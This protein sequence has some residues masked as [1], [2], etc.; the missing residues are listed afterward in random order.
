MP[1]AR[2]ATR[3]QLLAVAMIKSHGV[4]RKLRAA[5]ASF[6]ESMTVEIQAELHAI[7]METGRPVKF[8]PRKKVMPLNAVTDSSKAAEQRLPARAH[9]TPRSAFGKGNP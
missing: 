5:A 8:L 3:G 7:G 6:H 2:G 4:R 9:I 1:L